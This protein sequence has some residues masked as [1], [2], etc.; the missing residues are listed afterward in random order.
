MRPLTQDK[1]T[2]VSSQQFSA[3]FTR[4]KRVKC[5]FIE[6]ISAQ[7]LEASPLGC[8]PTRQILGAGAL[9]SARCRLLGC[10]L[11]CEIEK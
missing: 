1:A 6:G 9:I 5:L 3:E 8:G 7:E 4:Q 11:T 10:E 2:H